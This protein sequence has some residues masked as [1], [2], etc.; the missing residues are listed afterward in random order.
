M[1]VSIKH[2][3]K[4]TILFILL[5]TFIG[6]NPV[7]EPETVDSSNASS[8][9]AS[10]ETVSVNISIPSTHTLVSTLPSGLSLQGNLISGNIPRNSTLSIKLTAACYDPIDYVHVNI[11]NSIST[12]YRHRRENIKLK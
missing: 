4:R 1:E 12:T 7:I 6:C 10:V 9:E 2:V 11:K 8:S 5:T 3:L